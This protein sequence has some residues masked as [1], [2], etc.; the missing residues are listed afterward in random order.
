MAACAAYRKSSCWLPLSKNS[1]Y[2]ATCQSRS[3]QDAT[4]HFVNT[5]QHIPDPLSTFNTLTIQRTLSRTNTSILDRLLFTAYK[6]NRTLLT[7]IL[8]YI[9]RTPSLHV[10]LLLR[11][12]SHRR[13]DMCAVF[14]YMVRKGLY[15]EWEI[16]SCI[17]CLS[18]MI[19]EIHYVSAHIP[20][21]LSLC[22][23]LDT[24]DTRIQ[25]SIRKVLTTRLNGEEICLNFLWALAESEILPL[26]LRQFPLWLQRTTTILREDDRLQ[27]KSIPFT[28]RVNQH[29][30]LL[31]FTG[32]TKLF[33]K[34]RMDLW[35]EE[36]MATTWHPSRFQDWCLTEDEKKEWGM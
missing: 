14:G 21:A 24:D 25:Q 23:Y 12:R 26:R 34:R 29:P 9:R 4:E 33:L 13:P 36:L 6:H 35:K 1:P 32:P 20:T 19:R 2:C 8:N 30:L 7:Q 10:H 28:E 16:P 11:I 5:L 22:K 31:Q 18:H 27:Q 17:S 3:D 15:P